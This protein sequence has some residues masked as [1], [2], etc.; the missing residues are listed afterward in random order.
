[1]STMS[2]TLPRES[3]E[4]VGPITVTA[5]GVPTTA[6]KVAVVAAG[7]RPT[8]YVNPDLLGGAQGVL[9]GPGA[10]WPLPQG[11]YQVW[12]QVTA[13]TEVPV[14]DSVAQLVIT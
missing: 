1:V 10:T 2:W 8:A 12:V 6:F 14:L 3:K 13:A 7:T 4:W 5:N 9:V 11:V